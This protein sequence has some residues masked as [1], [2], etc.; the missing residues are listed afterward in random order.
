M[1]P[2]KRISVVDWRGN[3]LDPTYEKRARQ[4]VR[5]GRAAWVAQDA[6]RLTQ[7]QEGTYMEPSYRIV[8]NDQRFTDTAAPVPEKTKAYAPVDDPVMLERAKRRIA[9]RNGLFWQAFDFVLL[10]IALWGAVD[11]EIEFTVFVAMFW[12]VRFLY[13]V[14]KHIRP[15]FGGGIRRYLR[16]HRMRS[17]EAEYHRLQAH[18]DK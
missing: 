3:A 6:I 10:G 8:D 1:I 12:V 14:V 11:Y 17:L 18:E 2:I 4:F 9:E 16:E 15:L 7:P 13:R 5:T